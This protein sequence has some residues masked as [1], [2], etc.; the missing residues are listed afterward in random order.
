MSQRLVKHLAEL[1][2]EAERSG[3]IRG[4]FQYLLA[5][6]ENGGISKEELKE[7]VEKERGRHE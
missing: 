6:A 7:A 1:Y 4:W 2:V 5:E 3:V